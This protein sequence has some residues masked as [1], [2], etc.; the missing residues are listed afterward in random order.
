MRL[1]IKYGGNALASPD[2]IHNTAKYLKE[3][4]CEHKFVVV[5]S[6][7]GDTTDVLFEIS[8]M[9][10]AGNR[11]RV[12]DLVDHMMKYHN[13][14]VEGTIKDQNIRKETL[15]ELAVLFDEM[16]TVIAGFLQLREVTSRFKDYLLSY[17]ERFSI[18]V[19]VASLKE[20]GLKTTS[21]TGRKA[22]ILTDSSFGRS[23][24]LMD[25]TRLRVSKTL[26]DIMADDTIP[27]LGGYTG[28]DQHGRV[29]TFGRWGSDYTATIIGSC[30]DVDQVWLMG[31]MDGMMSADP[32]MVPEAQVLENI[33]YSEA[34]EMAM[35]GAKQIHHRTFEPVLDRNIPL[36]I[37]SASN[38]AHPG[39]L[40]TQGASDAAQKTIK[41]VSTMRGNDLID[42]RGFGMVG[43]PGTAAG[44]FEALAKQNISVMMIS[45]NP[46]ESSITI[47]IRSEDLHRAVRALETKQLGRSIR[48][49]NVIRNVAIVAVIGSG[50]RGTVGTAARVF[51][52]IS[53]RGINAIMITQGSSEINL[54][55]VIQDQDAKAAVRALHAKF[56][57]ARSSSP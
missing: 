44:I 3:L 39:T 35:F 29:T 46:S 32:K 6:A 17:G 27:V 25:T 45:Q 20:L 5:C 55:F 14:L 40:V 15:N 30:M 50:L 24:P 13:R 51:E 4:T 47:V 7:S 54:A 31:D 18:L 2:Q 48:R 21:L 38:T 9:I 49:L 23:R 10:K 12:D 36:R 53:D 28:A 57:L 16:R 8:S 56:G 37:R 1:V 52:S 19:M 22:G 34:I 41:C 42:I 43:E 33:S 11:R 26:G